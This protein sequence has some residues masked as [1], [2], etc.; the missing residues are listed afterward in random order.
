[1]LKNVNLLVLFLVKIKN[2]CFYYFFVPNVLLLSFV[3]NFA[4]SL[5]QSPRFLF[6]FYLDFYG[7]GFG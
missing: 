7:Q 3:L 6:V 5:P 4:C 2:T 1:M